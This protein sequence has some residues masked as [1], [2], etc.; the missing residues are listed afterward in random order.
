M[1]LKHT[2]LG[3]PI[4]EEVS[5][6]LFH[7]PIQGQTVQ[8]VTGRATTEMQQEV[9]PMFYCHTLSLLRNESNVLKILNDAH[10]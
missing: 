6:I 8:F 4:L 10:F 2:C 5:K 3:P 9:K 7:K 1:Q